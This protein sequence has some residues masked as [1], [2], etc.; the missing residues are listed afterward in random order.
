MGW[1]QIQNSFLLGETDY[2]G[3]KDISDAIIN[4]YSDLRLNNILLSGT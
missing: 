1:D 4:K 2:D 3:G